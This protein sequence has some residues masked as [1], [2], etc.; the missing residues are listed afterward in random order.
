LREGR[1]A[2]AGAAFRRGLD[3]AE[4]LPLAGGLAGELALGLR[5]AERAE[6]AAE[7]HRVA[8]RLRGLYGSDALAGEQLAA[9]DRLGRDFWQRRDEVFAALEDLPPAA[10]RQVRADLLELAL[11]WSHARVGLA[12]PGRGRE[13]RRETLRVLGELERAL[14]PSVVIDRERAARA[15]ELGLAEEARAAGRRADA[16]G[17]RSAWERYALGCWH[18]RAGDPARA[19]AELERAADEEPDSFWAQLYLGRCH[20][21][22]GRPAEALARF[23]VCVALRPRLATSYVHR[24]AAHAR[25]GELEQARR[26]A[27]RALRLDPADPE[28]RALRDAL[29]SP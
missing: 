25:L 7:L 6:A 1:G 19:L 20:L 29:R 10:G 3:L 24:G 13:E 2:S 27:E 17:P 11:L 23:T 18:L 4:G 8:E 26:D 12:G 5:R 9:V 28:A 22:L 14:G 16:A 15:A 21:R